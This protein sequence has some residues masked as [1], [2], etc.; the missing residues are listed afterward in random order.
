MSNEAQIIKPEFGCRYQFPDNMKVEYDGFSGS[1]VNEIVVKMADK[2]DS[3]VVDQIAMEARAEGISDITILNKYTILEALNRAMALPVLLK[4]GR[5]ICPHCY[6]DLVDFQS[7]S[8]FEF[9]NYC[10][11]CGQKLQWR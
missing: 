11:R 8:H 5:S 7:K 4:E 10:F 3:Y 6:Y 9:P 1:L 2:Y